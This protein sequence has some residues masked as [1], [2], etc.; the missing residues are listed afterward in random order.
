MYKVSIQRPTELQTVGY[1]KTIGEADRVAQDIR[2]N[3]VW[4]SRGGHKFAVVVSEDNGSEVP[5][6]AKRDGVGLWL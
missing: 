6:V 2:V 3:Q 4:G 5:V 1:Y